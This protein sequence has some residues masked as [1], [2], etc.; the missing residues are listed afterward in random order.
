[1]AF[2]IYTGAGGRRFVGEVGQ[3]EIVEA[4]SRTSGVGINSNA[5][6][7]AAAA[8]LHAIGLHTQ[9]EVINLHA[10]G[11]PGF[12]PANPVTQTT[13]CRFNDG[14]AYRRFRRGAR[15]PVRG[16]GV[17]TQDTPRFMAEANRHGFHFYLTYPGAVGERQHTNEAESSWDRSA[18]VDPTLKRGDHG[19]AVK[20]LTRMLRWLGRMPAVGGTYGPKVEAAVKAFQQDHHLTADGV[21]GPQTWATLRAAYRR[22]RKTHKKPRPWHRLTFKPPKPKPPRATTPV[23]HQLHRG[24]VNGPDVS[25]HNGDVDWRKV[26][27]GGNEFAF[28]RVADGDHHDARYSKARVDAMRKAKVIVGVYYYA[29]VASPGN[30]ERNGVQECDMALSLAHKA[31]W[32]KPGDLPLAYDFED[33]NGQTIAKA[34]R[35]LVQFVAR[36]H[37][38]TG[39]YPIVYSMPGMLTP[40]VG[41]LSAKARKIVGRCPLWL[42]Y[43]GAGGGPLGIK[44]SKVRVPRP[45]RRI[46]LWQFSW[47]GRQPGISGACDM[48]IFNGSY[49]AL[50]RL[51]IRR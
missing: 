50:L 31:G 34:A 40:I 16:R 9:Q 29:R 15:L 8:Q 19:L 1:M 33:L 41:A 11:V 42:A 4:I 44:V 21:A 45:W 48:S 36:Y 38:R 26:S 39:H 20:R 30:G 28:V 49:A 23:R 12:G 47:V 37:A 14:V 6:D 3:G 32:G 17:D 5:R 35:H 51:T 24:P 18:N 13:H 22:Y 43:V 7:Q 27:A 25:E 46:A 10:R 2:R